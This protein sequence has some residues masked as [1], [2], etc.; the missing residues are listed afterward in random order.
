MAIIKC[1]ECL[2]EISS[3]TKSCPH[4]G[5][6]FEK[7]PIITFKRV[8][9]LLL[10]SFFIYFF[11]SAVKSSGDIDYSN[12]NSTIRDNNERAKNIC[13]KTNLMGDAFDK[14]L[15]NNGYKLIH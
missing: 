7:K 5:A 10:I 11:I 3:T 6:N 4:C 9:K 15:I 13:L 14:C 12:N 2:N 1:G 8:M